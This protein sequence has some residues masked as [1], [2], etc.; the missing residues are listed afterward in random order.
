MSASDNLNKRL[1]VSVFDQPGHKLICGA[2]IPNDQNVF[3]SKLEG[4]VP[5]GAMEHFTSKLLNAENIVRAFGHIR[6]S[7]RGNQKAA[8]LR[9]SIPCSVIEECD[10][11]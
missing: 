2:A 11:P 9:I 10:L 7:H 6:E 8:L 3:I 1:D 4:V 5:S